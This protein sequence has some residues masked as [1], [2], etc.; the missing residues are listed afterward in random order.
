MIATNGLFGPTEWVQVAPSP[1][2]PPC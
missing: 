1:W 2:S